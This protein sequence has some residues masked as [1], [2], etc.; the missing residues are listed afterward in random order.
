MNT[1]S[2]FGVETN[3]EIKI[4]E[5]AHGQL[6]DEDLIHFNGTNW[7]FFE[8]NEEMILKTINTFVGDSLQDKMKFVRVQD[9]VVEAQIIRDIRDMDADCLE[10]LVEYMYHV[11][12]TYEPETETILL[13]SKDEGLTI[14]EILGQSNKD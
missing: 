4:P 2:A 1:I 14:G 6:V 7:L 11:E 10:G 12:A 13:K 9:N 3:K 8:P 5:V